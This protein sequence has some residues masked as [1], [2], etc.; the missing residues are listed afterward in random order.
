[1]TSLE[2]ETAFRTEGETV[3]R[4]RPGVIVSW[5]TDR[6]YGFIKSPGVDGTVFVHISAIKGGR[7]LVP[8][9]GDEVEFVMEHGDADRPRALQLIIKGSGYAWE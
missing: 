5:N 8:G 3:S 2:A 6:K 4:I 9:V 7:A 1:M